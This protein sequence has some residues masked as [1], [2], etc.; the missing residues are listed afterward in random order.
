V[1]P[2]TLG[3]AYYE[4][5]GM[6]AVQVAAIA[7]LPQELR[8]RITVIVVDDG[9]PT[10]PAALPAERPCDMRLYRMR[11]DIPWNQDACRN[12]AVAEAPTDWVL[13]TDM[14]HVPT[15]KL[16][17][18]AI[19]GLLDPKVVYTFARV[20]APD[21]APYKPH[22]NS[23]LLTR[24]MYD[25]VGGYDERYRGVYGTDGIFAKQLRQNARKIAPLKEVLIR[26]PRE[27][28]PDASTTTLARKSVENELR[29][30]AVKA[31]I[32]GSGQ[33]EPIRGLTAWDRVA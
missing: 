2:I 11:E 9:S 32:K 26:Y 27:V 33:R 19:E 17:R 12:L 6:L 21:M 15:G 20:S 30:A 4:N 13:L 10:A 7:K 29:R 18:R 28:V 31:Q 5:R 14:D 1:R 8:E 16:W 23:W 22:P 3:L 24:A 25:R